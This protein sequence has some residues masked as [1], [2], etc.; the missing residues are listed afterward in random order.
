LC[1]MPGSKSRT[2]FSDVTANLERTPF[3]R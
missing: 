3:G 1:L 2:L